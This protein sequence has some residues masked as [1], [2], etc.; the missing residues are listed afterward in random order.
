MNTNLRKIFVDHG[1]VTRI[2]LTLRVSRNTVRKALLGLSS[3]KK[4]MAIRTMALEKGGI[5]FGNWMA[6]PWKSRHTLLASS[7]EQA[8]ALTK[9][10][11][12]FAKKGLV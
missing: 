9:Q 4:A 12:V 8:S 3:T 11:R 6:P 5:E 1:M 2:A 10:N 7:E